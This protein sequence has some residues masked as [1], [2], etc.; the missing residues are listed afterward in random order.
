MSV[1][2]CVCVCVCVHGCVVRACV[3]VCV[4]VY[5]IIILC[6]QYFFL[7]CLWHQAL[8]P[9]H[10]LPLVLFF[11]F[12]CYILAVCFYSIGSLSVVMGSIHGL[13]CHAVQDAVGVVVFCKGSR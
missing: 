7:S 4:C 12:S 5:H 8:L 9:P 2:A 13:L 1:F 3:R 11:P 6:I 10:L